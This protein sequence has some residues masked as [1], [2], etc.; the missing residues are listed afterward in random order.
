MSGL[1][2]LVH[3]SPPQPTRWPAFVTRL[4]RLGIVSADP[5]IVRRQT[6][7][8]FAA[9]ATALNAFSHLVIGADH[10]FWGLMPLHVYNLA[11]FVI[12][13][14][15]HRLHRYGENAAAIVLCTLIVAGHSFVV[16]ALGYASDLQIYF[17]LVGFLFF[18]FGVQHWPTFLIFYIAAFVMLVVTV[19]FGQAGGFIAPDDTSYR[20]FQQLQALINTMIINGFAAAYTLTSLTRAERDLARQVEV[21]NAL[22]DALLPRQ[23]STRLKSGR[24]E[25][26]ADLVENATVMFA[27]QASFTPA[28]GAVSPERLVTYLEDLFFGFDRLCERHGVE[29]IKTI[30]DSYM[31]AAGLHG[32]PVAGAIAVGRLAFD[33]VDFMKEHGVLGDVP[34]Q[35]RIGI[36]SGPLVAGVIGNLRVSYDVW[37]NTVNIAQRMEA[38][39]EPGRIQV[40]SAFRAIAGDAFAYEERGTIAIK[41][42]GETKTWFLLK[43][44]DAA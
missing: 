30:G 9:Y 41:G 34:L 39:G 42:A 16:F 37:G 31:A 38:H 3:T 35:L 26:I 10:N 36:H 8:N 2:D 43:R 28:A 12:A 24:E 11:V 15:L 44:P 1:R 13:L 23:I 32:D 4:M 17:V 14:S 20:E 6:F 40:S 5:D 29:K 18:L 19:E 25:Q 7:T 22:V 27:D 21:S 33:L